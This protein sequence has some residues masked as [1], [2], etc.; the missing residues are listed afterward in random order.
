VIRTHHFVSLFQI[1]PEDS[2]F[3]HQFEARAIFRQVLE[4]GTIAP[5]SDTAGTIDL[6]GRN[7][8]YADSIAAL[9]RCVHAVIPRRSRS[10]LADP[11]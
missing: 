8:C 3:S 4:C 10:V 6:C 9:P 7:I 5:L 2:P 1:A 11:R